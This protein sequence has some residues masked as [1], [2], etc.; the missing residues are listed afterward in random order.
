MTV[1]TQVRVGCQWRVLQHPSG[2]FDRTEHGVLCVMAQSASSLI[3]KR[4]YSVA[5]F[6]R[7]YSVSR[8]RAYELMRDGM[9]EYRTLFSRRTIPVEGARRW[10]DSL[11]GN[12]PAAA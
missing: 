6:C 3:E 1:S 5:E 2:Q 8:S 11:P 4:A 10:Y 12:R 9:L 7:A